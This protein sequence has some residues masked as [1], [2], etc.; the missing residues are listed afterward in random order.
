MR[1]KTGR[2]KFSGSKERVSAAK[3]TIRVAPAPQKNAP[4]LSNS[5]VHDPF[6]VNDP[7]RTAARRQPFAR[8]SQINHEKG[9]LL[10]SGCTIAKQ[11]VVLFLYLI[12]VALF[13]SGCSIRGTFSGFLDAEIEAVNIRKMQMIEKQGNRVYYPGEASDLAPEVLAVLSSQQQFLQKYIGLSGERFGVAIWQVKPARRLYQI[14]PQPRN[15]HVW[16]LELV[17]T[18][19]LSHAREFDDLYHT[20]M[21]ERTEQ[22][23]VDGILQG[24]RD[25]YSNRQT[26]WIGDGLA[27]LIAYRFCCKH[28]NIAALYWLRGRFDVVRDLAKRWNVETLNLRHF[29]AVRG[30]PSYVKEQMSL[31][32]YYGTQVAAYYGMSFYYWHSLEKDQGADSIKEFVTG[33]QLLEKASNENIDDLIRRI[34]GPKYVNQIEHVRLEDAIRLFRKEMALLIPEV[35]ALLKSP[36]R[37]IR[38]AAY[39]ALRG[40]DKD[41]FPD[42][43][44]TELPTT[45]IIFDIFP[46][47]PA[48]Q[49]GLRRN[50]IVESVDGKPVKDYNSFCQRLP[51]YG[52]TI[53]LLR[54]NSSVELEIDSF[55]GCKFKAVAR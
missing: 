14:A 25:L 51:I 12:C 38:M 26:R 9:F 23:V 42:A 39:E 16:T 2:V 24:H 22:A 44:P 11:L 17:N 8:V 54:G 33:L 48:Y 43:I 36:R 28:S 3:A 52:S 20:F 55:E 34:G 45:A 5:L 46:A 32:K 53:K 19:R 21:H 13:L 10:C 41:I 50:D 30:S 27:E 7:F 47:S 18:S 15:W 31:Y 37:S 4:K 1:V 40:L 49:S 6:W 29:L 35:Q